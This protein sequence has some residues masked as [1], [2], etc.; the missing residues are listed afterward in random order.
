[1]MNRWQ[2]RTSLGWSF[3]YLLIDILIT[4]QV[5]S[6]AIFNS[7]IFGLVPNGATHAEAVIFALILWVMTEIWSIKYAHLGELGHFAAQKRGER[8]ERQRAS[9]FGS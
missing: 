8:K 1:M 4:I 3:F 6:V 2:Y 7:D 9:R 5:V